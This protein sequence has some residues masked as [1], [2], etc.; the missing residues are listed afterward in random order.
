MWPFDLIVQ[1]KPRAIFKIDIIQLIKI[2][3]GLG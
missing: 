2:H 1:M 3:L